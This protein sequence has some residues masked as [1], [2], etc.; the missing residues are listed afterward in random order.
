VKRQQTNEELHR[1]H[2]VDDDVDDVDVDDDVDDVDVV[3]VGL[4]YLSG[5]ERDAVARS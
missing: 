5:R 2:D 4:N 3:D 1:S